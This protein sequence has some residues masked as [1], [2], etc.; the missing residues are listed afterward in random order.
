MYALDKTLIEG[1]DAL[2]PSVRVLDMS[3]IGSVLTGDR[4][5]L[6]DGPAVHALLIQNQNPVTVCPDSN[7]VRRDTLNDLI[8]EELALAHAQGNSR[9]QLTPSKRI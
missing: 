4:R 6:G 3:R 1:L 2:D 5:D 9:H 7:K 8:D